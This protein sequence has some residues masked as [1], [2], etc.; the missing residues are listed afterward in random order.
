[1]VFHC[2]RGQKTLAWLV[3]K[4]EGRKKREEEGDYVLH[5]YLILPIYICSPLSTP[6]YCWTVCIIPTGRC[7]RGPRAV[8]QVVVGCLLDDS[9]HDLLMIWAC[10]CLWDLPSYILPVGVLLPFPSVIIPSLPIPSVVTGWSILYPSQPLKYSLLFPPH[11]SDCLST[12]ILV[13]IDPTVTVLFYSA[14]VLFIGV[15]TNSLSIECPWWLTFILRYTPHYLLFQ[16]WWWWWLL[17]L[18]SVQ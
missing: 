5:W 17:I 10:C 15:M 13:I 11:P 1:M 12:V 7:W 16:W 14:V 2:E 4:K 3:E 6:W 18:Y 8:S 9:G